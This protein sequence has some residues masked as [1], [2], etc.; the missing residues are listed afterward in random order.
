MDSSVIR[1]LPISVKELVWRSYL[2]SFWVVPG[3]LYSSTLA[4][5]IIKVIETNVYVAL[6]LSTQ[7]LAILPMIST[8]EK[9][10]D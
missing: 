1:M 3:M 8:T 5:P 4:L 2:N 9:Y 10:S 6:V 7:V